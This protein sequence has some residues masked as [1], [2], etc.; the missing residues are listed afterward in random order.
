MN[1]RDSRAPLRSMLIF[2]GKPV[3][4]ITWFSPA[5]R[6]ESADYRRESANQNMIVLSE[7]QL[8]NHSAR[9]LW[10][11]QSPPLTFTANCSKDQ[12]FKLINQHLVLLDLDFEFSTP[13]NN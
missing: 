3:D 10:S 13:P 12:A 4:I 8:S 7:Q 5:C 1:E 6:D 11:R 9:R 2:L